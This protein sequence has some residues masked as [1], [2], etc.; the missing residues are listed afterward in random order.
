MAFLMSWIF[1]VVHLVQKLIYDLKH[2][3]MSPVG[4]KSH[5]KND[6]DLNNREITTWFALANVFYLKFAFVNTIGSV[7]CIFRHV[8]V[9]SF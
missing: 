9:L 8:R 6:K 5:K 4:H 7:V 1:S 2:T 3:G